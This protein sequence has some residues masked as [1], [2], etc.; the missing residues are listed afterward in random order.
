MQE[1]KKSAG[2]PKAPRETASDDPTVNESSSGAEGTVSA[3]PRSGL[4]VALWLLI[5]VILVL[6]VGWLTR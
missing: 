4:F 3:S 5:P 6:V 2:D 1:K